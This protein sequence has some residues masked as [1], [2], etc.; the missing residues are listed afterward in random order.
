MVPLAAIFRQGRQLERQPVSAFWRAAGVGLQGFVLTMVIMSFYTS[1][2]TNDALPAVFWTLAGCCVA[3]RLR[4]QR[5]PSKRALPSAQSSRQTL[6]S[7]D[8]EAAPLRDARD[9]RN[10]GS[11]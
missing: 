6:S 9:G 8:D 11:V 3:M 7:L 1:P 10:P 4:S 2:F 5:A